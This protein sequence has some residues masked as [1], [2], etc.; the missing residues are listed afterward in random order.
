MIRNKSSR[1]EVQLHRNLHSARLVDLVAPHTEVR[2]LKCLCAANSAPEGPV[3]C[4]ERLAA[5][6]EAHLFGNSEILGER[7]VLTQVGRN[8]K[9]GL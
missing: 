7:E 1:S 2:I 4:I 6:I 5:K 8:R 3:E 9:F